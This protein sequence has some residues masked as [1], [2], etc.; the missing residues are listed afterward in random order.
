MLQV[1]I[2]GG[3]GSGKSTVCKVF[4]L[5]GV[6]VYYAD[7]RARSLTNENPTIVKSLKEL[8]GE[9][10]YRD[11]IFDKK[12]AGSIVFKNKKILQ[13]IN[14][15]IHPVVRDDYEQW[16]ANSKQ[17]SIVIK[18]VAILYESNLQI[19]FDKVITVCASNELKI[20]RVAVRDG[21][22]RYEIVDRINNQ[23]S[24]EKKAE[25]SDFIIKSDDRQLVIPQ[26]IKIYES[27]LKLV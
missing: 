24:D 19:G 9:D 23:W 20:R 10:I 22:S 6:P 3:I 26:I 11:N 1:G 21:L 13:Q 4:E 16:V 7:L 27:L 12:R 18:E 17:Y 25:L 15:I 14:S 2:T 5:L 8:F